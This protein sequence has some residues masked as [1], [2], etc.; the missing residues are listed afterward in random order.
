MNLNHPSITRG[1]LLSHE[2][3]RITVLPAGCDQQG[4]HETRQWPDTI[5]TDHAP[6][7]AECCTEL[8]ADDPYDGTQVVRGLMSA[9]AITAVIAAIVAVAV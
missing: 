9:I 4:R 2:M 3:H 7:P 8:G 1:P 6:L 5:P